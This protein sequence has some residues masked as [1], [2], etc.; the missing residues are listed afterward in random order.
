M[1]KQNPQY[2]DLIKRKFAK[3]R[4][5][6]TIKLGWYLDNKLF[7]DTDLKK[8]SAASGTIK[9]KINF[10]QTAIAFTDYDILT[11]EAKNLVEKIVGFIRENN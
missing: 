4:N 10:C 7:R 5:Y 2:T 8:Y 11:D 3:D 9:D 1:I 6:K